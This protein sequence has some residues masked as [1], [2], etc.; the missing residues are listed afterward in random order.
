MIIEY[1]VD[2]QNL[3]AFGQLSHAGVKRKVDDDEEGPPRS[4]PKKQKKAE[5]EKKTGGQ[6]AHL[7]Y[8]VLMF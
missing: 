8:L 3:T 2:C 1:C 7:P 5:G 4:K 6:I